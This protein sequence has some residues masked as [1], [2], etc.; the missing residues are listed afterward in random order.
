VSVKG[1]EYDRVVIYG[2]ADYDN[3]QSKG[4][5]KKLLVNPQFKPSENERLSLEYFINRLYVAMTRPRKQLFILDTPDDSFWTLLKN[6]IDPSATDSISWLVSMIPDNC[7]AR[8][9]QDSRADE[10]ISVPEEGTREGLS[11]RSTTEDIMKNAEQL[12]KDGVADKRIDLLKFAL[13]QLE[14]AGKRESVQ[15][16]EV[17]ACIAYLREEFANA[18]DEFEKAGCYLAS[19]H[20]Y[21]MALHIESVAGDS[22]YVLMRDKIAGLSRDA[23]FSLEYTLAQFCA[24]KDCSPMAFDEVISK[25]SSLVNQASDSGDDYSQTCGHNVFDWQN[26]FAQWTS[27]INYALKK[28]V[29]SSVSETAE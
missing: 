15:Y 25:F 22:S 1:L 9:N 26:D 10:K 29:E 24:S 5:F 27:V 4:A 21:F 7:K 18:A 17:K 13:S 11:G 14:H 28:F 2:F 6:G 23:K 16:H 12:I 3:T 8:W 20:C 19:M